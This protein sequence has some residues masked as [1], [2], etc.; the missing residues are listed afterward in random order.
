MRYDIERIASDTGFG[1]SVVEKVCRISDLLTEVYQD[2]LLKKRLSLTGGTALNLIY[3]EGIPR[4]SVDLDFN[5]RHKESVDWGKVRTRIDDRLKAILE[6][7]GYGDLK[8][9]PSYPLGRIN[10]AY[11]AESGKMDELK[12]E[13]GYMRRFPF[14]KEDIIEGFHHIGKDESI[15]VLTPKREELFASKILAGMKRKTPRD[16]FDIATISSMDFDQTLLRKCAVLES[17]TD[18]IR[19]YK[20]DIE[21]TFE[22]VDVD[23]A[24]SNLLRKDVT[25]TVDFEDVRT[26]ATDLLRNLQSDLTPEEVSVIETFYEDKE[27]DPDR[28]VSKEQ[29]HEKLKEHPAIRWT[30]ENL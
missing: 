29:F 10:A 17:F 13:V 12:I 14:L 3:T 25:D 16:V 26:R 11:S 1:P 4:L 2:P 22:T 20:L 21:Q 7:M 30:L 9:N 6:S 18:N 23:T 5:Y 24:L 27:F 28:I 15:K 19:L 8:I